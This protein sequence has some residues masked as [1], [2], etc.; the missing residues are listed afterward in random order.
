MPT[1]EFKVEMTCEGCSGAVTRI[2]TKKL[3]ADANFNVDLAAQKVTITSDLSQDE[4]TEMLKK[5][6]KAVT[7]IGVQ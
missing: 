2:L 4:L 1:Y 5:S 3:G 7:Y 6:G